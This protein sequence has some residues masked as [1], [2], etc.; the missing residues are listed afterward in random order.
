MKGINSSWIIYMILS[1]LVRLWKRRL[2]ASDYQNTSNNWRQ[3]NTTSCGLIGVSLQ[4]RRLSQD[5]LKLTVR[6]ARNWGKHKS[7]NYI[8]GIS[9]P[10]YQILRFRGCEQCFFLQR[11]SV[12]FRSHGIPSMSI[13]H[14]ESKISIQLNVRSHFASSSCYES[15]RSSH[16]CPRSARIQMWRTAIRLAELR[17]FAKSWN[18]R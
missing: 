12:N 13:K 6:S 8:I 1:V 14:S 7:N 16:Y 17:S 4:V 18:N 10:A 11:L 2:E 9:Y 5:I 15:V 3:R